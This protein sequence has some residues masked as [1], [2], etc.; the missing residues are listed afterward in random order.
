MRRPIGGPAKVS[1]AGAS[2]P[3]QIQSPQ[4]RS[5]V[6]ASTASAEL[7]P[8]PSSA[9]VQSSFARRSPMP[10]D[11]G[12]AVASPQRSTS[13]AGQLASTASEPFSQQPQQPPTSSQALFTPDSAGTATAAKP[14]PVLSL[15]NIALLLV[16]LL[17]I[18]AVAVKK[19]RRSQ[20]STLLSL[21]ARAGLVVDSASA[22][23]FARLRV[24]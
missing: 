6:L 10:K 8:A 5:P 2:V 4:I 15:R 9:A 7:P 23:D 21:L 11:L 1:G 18:G 17:S 3:F 24:G 12:V 19:V 22:P 20:L 14:S 16:L 13:R